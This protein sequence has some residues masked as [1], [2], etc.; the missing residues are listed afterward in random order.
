VDQSDQ[1][2]EFK[3][4]ITGQIGSAQILINAIAPSSTESPLGQRI[5]Q[6]LCRLDGQSNFDQPANCLF[7]AKARHS[8]LREDSGL[9]PLFWWRK[10]RCKH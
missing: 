1:G 3:T 8:V 6:L 9:R 5:A 7:G 4:R 2:R 10:A